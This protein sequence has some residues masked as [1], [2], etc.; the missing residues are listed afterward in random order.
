MEYYSS[1]ARN[2]AVTHAAMRATLEDI[3]LSERSQM[4]KTTYCMIPCT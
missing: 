2:E 1:V 4:Q 3:T